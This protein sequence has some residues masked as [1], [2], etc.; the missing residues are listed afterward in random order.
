MRDEAPVRTSRLPPRRPREEARGRAHPP[1]PAARVRADAHR[2][3]AAD[4][5]GAEA[6]RVPGF[7]RDRAVP[8]QP[9]PGHGIHGAGVTLV[10]GC[11]HAN[12]AAAATRNG[13]TTTNTSTSTR[14]GTSSIP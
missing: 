8:V 11:L 1:S 3:A 5:G 10:G 13:D 4:A 6:V 14:R 12:S 2:H 9:G 7:P